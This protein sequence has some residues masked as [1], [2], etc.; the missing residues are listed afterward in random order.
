M[1]VLRL[2][3]ENESKD[4]LRFVTAGSVD[5]GK[6]TLIG[7]LLFE[8][9]GIFEDQLSAIRAVTDDGQAAG[10]DG[11]DLAL[12]T[13]GLKAEREQGITIDVAYR[14]FATPRRKFIIADTPGHEQYT[15]NTATGASTALL[16]VILIDATR[17]V[18]TQ[19]KRHAFIAS[20]LGIPHVVVAV[21]K[22]DLVDYDQGVFDAIRQ[23]FTDFA[24]RLQFA[25]VTFIPVSALMGDNVVEPGTNMDWYTGA[26]LLHH[27]ETVHI[28]SDR[29]LIDLRFPVQYVLRPD[30][31]SRG[32]LGTVSSGA[33]RPGDEITVIPSGVRTRV[34]SVF[35]PDGDLDEG[36]C[37]LAVGVTL[38][39]DVD[40]SRG[41]MLA[42]VRNVPRV[43]RTV[44][45]MILWMAPEPMRT[46]T[47]YLIKHLTR[48]LPAEISALRYGVDV[49]TLHRHDTDQLG[50][51]EI[52]RCVVRLGQPIAYDPYTRN[53]STGAFIVVDRVTNRTVGAGMILDRDPNEWTGEPAARVST[54][55][56]THVTGHAGQVSA[57]ERAG[58]LGHR[59]A[60]VWLTGLT[61][62][63]KSTLAY[64]VERRLFDL[65]CAAAVIDG[66]N[67]RLG[68]S[69]DLGF[70]ADD[71]AENVRRAAE[72]ARL[73]NQG[74][75]I[76]LCALLSP[77]AATR[78]A[79]AGV[80]G[81]DR[82]VEVYLSAPIDVCRRRKPD[83]Y[84]KA[85]SG[86]IKHFSGVTAAYEPPDGPDLALPTD[87]MDVDACVDRIV[88]LLRE[89]GIVPKG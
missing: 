28:A 77:E 89:R 50:L 30:R 46:D 37:P 33:V 13:D 55:K 3:E 43:D 42:H 47:P 63:G 1:D 73:L 49:N 56:S 20:L 7:R 53:R 39:D 59:P 67:M 44:E 38:E 31:R 15:R 40:V 25:D 4:L 14:Y 86:E 64:A 62:A 68:L 58:R 5:D 81:T 24:A 2:L 52:G 26:T 88:E 83:T 6:S 70:G 17:G 71:R 35:G 80:I 61:G 9:K 16:A 65:D 79:S 23:E 12:V 11:V 66:E 78:R 10:R 82:Y 32:Y 34:K 22:M 87:E 29:N 74:G 51:N 8:S 45:A 21:N 19:S 36:F 57:D 18:L 27:L 75:L 84:A 41:D 76:A 60:T 85:D 72:A 69:K 48:T 54:P